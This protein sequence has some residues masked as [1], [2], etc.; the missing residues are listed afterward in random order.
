MA[1]P[2]SPKSHTH[3]IT[4]APVPV[5]WA[6]SPKQTVSLAM[7]KSTLGRG[8]TIIS[9]VAVSAQPCVFVTINVTVKVPEA[10]N[11]CEGLGNVEKLFTPELGSPK[12]QDHEKRSGPPLGEDK[13]VNKTGSPKQSSR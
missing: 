5:N 13:S 3:E 8:A 11:I 2:P 1:V 9:C 6:V 10:V 12:S 7:V 4:L